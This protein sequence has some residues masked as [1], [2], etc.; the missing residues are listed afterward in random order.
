MIWQYQAKADPLQPP[1][2]QETITADKWYRQQPDPIRRPLAVALLVAGLVSPL[3]PPPPVTVDQW[4]GSTVVPVRAPA[5][6]QTAGASV[7]DPVLV[8]V[9]VDAWASN[10]GQ[11]IRLPVRPAGG[12]FDAIG[13][14][15]AVTAAD[16]QGFDDYRRPT[17]RPMLWPVV[18][19]P[20]APVVST[21][22]ITVDKWFALNP[23]PD[24]SRKPQT[25]SGH[26]GPTLAISN[27][28]PGVDAWQGIWT[29][30]QACRTPGPLPD[31]QF[32]IAPILG[33]SPPPPPSTG[34]LIL[35][36]ATPHYY[37][38]LT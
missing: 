6:R 26:F 24:R 31:F 8:P 23:Q 13:P 33:S 18:V 14:L 19:A 22:I 7:I 38:W 10:I 1:A 9:E 32:V 15:R 20:I 30:P 36:T 3:A 25:P 28:V 17:P 29:Q 21:E 4:Q 12:T 35:R 34:Y 27:P 2:A 16:W 37:V 11:P 5:P